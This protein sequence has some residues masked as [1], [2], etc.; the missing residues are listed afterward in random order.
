MLL[1]TRLLLCFLPIKR[2]YSPN[3]HFPVM[4]SVRAK[5][6]TV[7]TR[8]CSFSLCFTQQDAVGDGRLRPRA[9][10]WR[11]RRHTCGLWCCPIPSIIWNMASSTKPEIHSVSHCGQRR[12]KPRSQVTSTE[13]SVNFGR[14]FLDMW[15]DR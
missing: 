2:T 12:T 5:S 7:N 10:T 1:V 14:V 15:A 13:K 6:L 9:A 3:A 4:C 8:T 11:T